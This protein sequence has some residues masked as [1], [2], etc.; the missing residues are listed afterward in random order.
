[1]K[2]VFC[3]L[4]VGILP[5]SSL[6]AILAGGEF[7]LPDDAP[8]L[9]LDVAGEFWFVGALSITGGTGTYKGS[10]V[11]LSPEWLLTAGHNA[12]LDDDGLADADWSATIHLPDIGAFDLAYAAVNPNFSG[13]ANP[14]VHDDL[15][16]GL[17][18]SLESPSQV[19]FCSS[20]FQESP[21]S[22][23]GGAFS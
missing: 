16:T 1:M 7:D 6:H 3:L 10:A 8:S 14:S 12:D 18:R 11:A 4:V 9:R 19:L 5:V 22:S 17:S 20:C 23:S 2:A 15:A 21:G 13:F